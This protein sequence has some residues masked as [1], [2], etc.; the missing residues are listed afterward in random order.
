MERSERVSGCKIMKTSKQSKWNRKRSRQ[1]FIVLMLAWPV[2]HFIFS[3]ALN[4]NMIFLAFQDFTTSIEGVFVGFRNFRDIFRRFDA[5]NV[6][7]EW[8]SV[9]NTLSLLPLVILINIPISLMFSYLLYMKLPGYKI[10]QVLLYLPCITS[11]VVL[12]LVFRSFLVGGPFNT[13]L[14]TLNMGDVIPFDG[15]LS[16]KYAWPAILIFS[17][18]TSFSANIIYFLSAMRRI[19][20]EFVEA[21]K[22]DGATEFLIFIKIVLPLSMPTV[23]TLTMLGVAG[24]VGWSMPAFLMMD[25]MIGLNNTGTVGLSLLNLANSRAYG[26]ASAYGLLVTFIVAPILLKL[27]QW[28]NKITAKYEY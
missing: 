12:V 19:P 22:I 11:T 9:G 13:I 20:E 17:I 8:I 5:G 4:I 16:E 24:L 10:W 6:Y 28:A 27:R 2:A 18:W 1:L 15:W 26:T 25:S 23:S 7:N 21:A 14:N 3:W